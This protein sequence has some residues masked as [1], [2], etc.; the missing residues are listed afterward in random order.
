M[1]KNK[2]KIWLP[3]VIV[4][5]LLCCC[6]IVLLFLPTFG[7]GLGT[8]M[9]FDQQPS[10]TPEPTIVA[11]TAAG[12]AA[13]SSPQKSATP[14]LP[15]F[16]PSDDLSLQQRTPTPGSDGT[17]AIES[18]ALSGDAMETLRILEEA[19]V[20]SGDLREQAL[21]LSGVQ[22]IPKTLPGADK[23]RDV[24]AKDNFWV[25]NTDSNENFQIDAIL[26]YK[27]EHAYFW[28]E[29]GVRFDPDDLEALAETFESDIYK[30]NREF[31]GSEWTPG[32]DE[33]PHLYVLFASG[34][35]VNLAGYFSSADSVHPLAHEYSNA[36]EMFLM[37]ADN[38]GMDER[39]TYGVLAHEFQHM[40]HWYRDR[41]ESTW[42][43]EGFA[44]LAAFLNGYYESGFDSLYIWEPDMQLNDWPNDPSATTPHY[45]AAFLFVSYFLD[46]FGD[47]ATKMLV[48]D[49]DNSMSS[50]DSVLEVLDAQDPLTGAA[51]RADDVFADWVVTNYLLDGLVGDG[52]YTYRRYDGAQHAWETESFT[53]CPVDWGERSVHQ[54]GV[55]YISIACS[56]AYTLNFE[57][58]SEVG[59]LPV[60]PY[61]GDYAIWSN[62]GDDSDM[63]LT[64]EFDFSAV[65][66][67]LTLSFWTWYDLEE[68]YDYLY[69]EVSEDGETWEIIT[70]PSGTLED[71]SGNSY[72]WGYNGKT[73]GW[74]QEEV[75]LS[76]YAGKQVSVRF[77]YITDAAVNGEGM[78][79]DDIS[80]PQIGYF[81][82]L[83]TDDGGW[84]ARGFVRI[85]N[86]LP[87][88]YQISLI[89]RSGYET[90]VETIAL[91][92]QQTFSLPLDFGGE[93]N[94]A[95]LVV[96]GVTRFTR[97]EADYRFSLQP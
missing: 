27:T 20:P 1:K 5:V 46:R 30:T 94:E 52:R 7:I 95:V 26:E 86:R 72:G 25:T 78:L 84:D 74:V 88:T 9:L 80:I 70:T 32:I 37:N 18:D 64:Q 35:G 56:G 61:S 59:A 24:G 39:F 12:E 58:A 65:S 92:D 55:D 87:Q 63:T 43:N 83:E 4:V 42:L 91:T 79:L 60:D 71:P 11:A 3:I 50:V 6:C 29:D 44:E 48:A 47:E 41:N 82:D 69:L 36:H 28:V 45:G 77:E 31:F 51:V 90:S 93:M 38:V 73:D 49:L 8:L 96:S 85:Q 75:D 97:Q 15:P 34:L 10:S 2:V 57:G 67:D 40:I 19:I 54:Y 66:G 22:D 62:K 16:V 17:D 68:D 53:T 89:R 14:T 81:S 33:D 23:D 21:R 76:Q 13:P